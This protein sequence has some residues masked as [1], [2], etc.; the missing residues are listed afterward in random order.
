MAKSLVEMAADIVKAQCTST[1]MSADDVGVALENVFGVLQTL[2]SKE[3]TADAGEGD[4]SI[5]KNKAVEIAPEKSI[6]KNKII[7][8]ECGESFKMLSPKHLAGHGLTGREYRK[9]YG[10]SLRQ[11]LCAKSLSERRKKAGKERGVPEN[12]LKAIA[13]RKKNKPQKGS[14]EK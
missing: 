8:L 4:R 2:Q 9:K 13:A 14:A 10:F 12:L 7:C 5:E 6:L 11:P 1:S 3:A